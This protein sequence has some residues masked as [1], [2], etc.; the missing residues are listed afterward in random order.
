MAKR[1]VLLLPLVHALFASFLVH[2]AAEV[3]VLTDD[4][5]DDVTGAGKWLV[6]FYAPWC[7][8]C[9]QL[10]PLWKDLGQKAEDSDFNVAKLDAT[11]HRGSSQ[12]F[13]IQGFPT[14]KFIYDGNVYDY[15]G[16]RS[17]DKFANFAKTGYKSANS[18]P[19]PRASA[20]LDGLGFS[21]QGQG[22]PQRNKD[23]MG[24]LPMSRMIFNQIVNGSLAQPNTEWMIK[25]YAPWCPHCKRMEPIFDDLADEFREEESTTRVAKI[26]CTFYKNKNLCIRFDVPGYPAVL[27]IEFDS[28]KEPHFRWYPHEE[29]SLKALTK[30]AKGEYKELASFPLPPDVEN[31]LFDNLYEGGM[32]FLVRYRDYILWGFIGIVGLLGL[33]IGWICCCVDSKETDKDR[34]LRQEYILRAR[35]EDQERQQMAKKGAATVNV[36]LKKEE[37]KGMG[38]TLEIRDNAFFV[39]GLKGVA[40]ASGAINVDDCILSINGKSLEN[41]SLDTVKGLIGGVKPGEEL[42]LKLGRSKED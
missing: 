19:V 3:V 18:K 37:G 38:M 32:D 21:W 16:P 42:Q 29:R 2:T 27:H 17:V 8:H 4:N 7:G 9:K 12:R 5:F 15:Q 14:I 41:A 26:D 20:D 33:F 24:A 36:A 40:E 35:R 23:G 28:T 34:L 1:W 31:S 25:F 22:K 30:F 13:G 11:V 6:E 10:A 39:K